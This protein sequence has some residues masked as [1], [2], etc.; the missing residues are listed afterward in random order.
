MRRC[1][2]VALLCALLSIT[3]V[4]ATAEHYSIPSAGIQITTADAQTLVVTR[5]TIASQADALSALGIDADALLKEHVASQVLF[6]LFEKNGVRVQLTRMQTE[7]SER[8]GSAKELSEHERASLLAVFDMPPHEAAVWLDTE[9]PALRYADRLEVDGALTAFAH[10]ITIEQ[11][12]FYQF[13]AKG[14]GVSPEMLHEANERA[15]QGLDILPVFP[16]QPEA[17]ESVILPENI[18]DDGTVTPL[19]LV[20]YTGVSES[21]TSRITV[22]TLPDTELT[23]VTA[24]DSVRGRADEKGAHTFSLSTKRETLYDYTLIATA[25]GRERSEMKIQLQRRVSLEA[26]EPAYKRGAQAIERVGYENVSTSDVGTTILFRGHV[27]EITSLYGYPCVRIHTQNPRSGVWV[28]P[29]YVLLT[30]QTPVEVGGIYTVYA[31]VTGETMAAPG[32][33][34]GAEIPVLLCHS[35]AK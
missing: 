1:T 31:D 29:L 5:D 2:V 9:L 13:T 14:K 3:G 23:L 11:G 26:G 24:N 25:E 33:E 7:D 22:S 21:D 6:E 34:G 19:A 18:A 8:I 12:M 17:E 4:S 32:E 15:L 28:A 35:M 16:Y 10:L 20:D 30:A 27:E